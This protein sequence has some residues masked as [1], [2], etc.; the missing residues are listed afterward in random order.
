MRYLTLSFLFAL[1]TT[2]LA[3]PETAR[4]A[5]QRKAMEDSSKEGRKSLRLLAEVL[6]D[7][8]SALF[9]LVVLLEKE[10]RILVWNE[11]AQVCGAISG[12]VEASQPVWR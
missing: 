7:G 5:K 2:A 1:S 6:E 11:G 4:N 9:P 12:S 8:A 10:D 3:D